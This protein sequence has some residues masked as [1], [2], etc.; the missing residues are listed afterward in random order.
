MR[1]IVTIPAY[2]EERTV[3]DVIRSIPRRMEGVERVEVVVISDGSTDRTVEEARFAG[4]D[5]VVVFKRNRGLAPTFQTGLDAALA[6]GADLIVNIDADGQYVGAEIPHLVAPLLRGEADIVLGSR[7]AGTIEEMPA[8]KIW[9]NR[10]ATRITRWLSGLPITD[11]QTGFRAFSREAA[12]RMSIFS[13]YTYVQETLLQ[14]SQKG[15]KV[16]EV[17][18]GF[19]RREG[20]ESRLIRGVWSYARRAGATILRTYLYHRPLKAFLY[21][22]AVFLAVGGLVGL[23]VLLHFL[24][25]GAV[26]GFL[27]SALLS[28]LLL[29]LGA[30]VVVVGLLA[31]VTHHNSLLQEE[32]LYRLKRES[33]EKRNR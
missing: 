19:R 33:L 20:G 4:A 24:Q 26:G 27:P 3:G 29:I 12:L 8:S 23:R 32:V 30:Q 6:R 17:P 16:V 18:V 9:G 25:T 15:L 5:E 2:N 28:A 10:V 7:F 13:S 11:A 31:D 1:L 14:A 22:G 21:L